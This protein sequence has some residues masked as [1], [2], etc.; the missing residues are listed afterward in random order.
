MEYTRREIAYLATVIIVLSLVFGFNDGSEKF[1]MSYWLLNFIKIL[2]IVALSV[3]IHDFAHDMMA[4]RY[5]FLSEYRVWG[6]KRFGFGEPSFPKQINLFGK[7]FTIHSFPLGI[8]I[9]LLVTL[10]SNG[11][12]FF[13]AISSYGLV[14][15][16]THRI[17]KRFI[18]VT[19]F[20]EAKIALAGPMANIL[21]VI[22]FKLFN[23]AGTFDAV[24]MV[25]TWM[26]FWDM[27]PL[28]GLDGSKVFWGSRPLYVFSFIFILGIVILSSL[29]GLSAV[30]MLALS[31][32]VA[33]LFFVF[34]IYRFFN[35]G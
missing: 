8:I 6:L 32:V 26:A 14:I 15:K 5:G 13:T 27:F 17:G 16:K 12:A 11:R 20:E 35:P 10:L 33:L 29:V 30:P 24:I 31:L 25:N 28:P 7:T 1:E 23:S 4:K 21:L 34:Y 19:D 2:V 22:I 18:E 3:L 9:A